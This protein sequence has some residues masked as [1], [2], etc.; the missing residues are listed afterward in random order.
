MSIKS[1]LSNLAGTITAAVKTTA[2]VSGDGALVTSISPDGNAVTVA[3]LPLP[4]GGS[5]S[6]LQTAGNAS[7]SSIDGKAPPLSSGRVPVDGSGV[8]QPVSAASLPLP[9]GAATSV[10]QTT[11]NNSLGTL[12]TNSATLGQKNMAGSS[13]VVFASDQSALAVTGTFY[14]ATQ[15]VSGT[16]A[17]T[18]SGTW[19]VQPGN[20]AN[21]TAWLMTQATAGSVTGGT[22]GT[23][24]GLTG[25]IYNTSAPTLTNG[26]QAALQFDVN[27]NLKINSAVSATM[28]ATP[29]T[30]RSGTITVG[31]TSQQ[32]SASNA[33]RKGMEIQNGST[34]TESLFINFGAAATNVPGGGSHE[35]TPGGSWDT[36]GRAPPSDAI[37]INAVTT[38]HAFTAKEW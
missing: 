19:T 27:G 37:N 33:A 38:A 20:N 23:S 24:S 1:F 15:P 36:A 10:L 3:S 35:I 12:V 26:Q 21:T 4:A 32:V 17:A 18:Q 34:A 31:G 13:P 7:L 8:T 30:D 9:A 16:V 14:Q 6:A 28:A 2:P 25:G 5:T 11:G 22:A 29:T